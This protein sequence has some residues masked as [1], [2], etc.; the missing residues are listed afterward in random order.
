MR[1]Y[2]KKQPMLGWILSAVLMLA[3][4]FML[5]RNFSSR[6]EVTQLTQLVT[7]R[8]NET[9]DTWQV[10]RGV[11]EKQLIQRPYPID[12]SEGVVNP[13]TGKPTGFPIDDWKLTIDRINAERQ[14]LL[15]PNKP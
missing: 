9:G 5:W 11:L 4:A 3:A 10:P 14:A 13:K 15:E 7:I 1:E 12:P 2:L 8:C 6:N